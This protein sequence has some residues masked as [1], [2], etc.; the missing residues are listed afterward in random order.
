[1]HAAQHRAATAETRPRELGPEPADG[2][3]GLGHGWKQASQPCR[4]TSDDS[5]WLRVSIKW[6][7]HDMLEIS[8]TALPQRRKPTYWIQ[9]ITVAMCAKASGQARS[10]Q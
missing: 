3:P 2:L 10:C 5:V 4:F 1:M 7:W 9:G 8:V 6:V